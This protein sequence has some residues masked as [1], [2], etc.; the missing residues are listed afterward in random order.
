M[1]LPK[2]SSPPSTA[3]FRQE[4]AEVSSVPD[5]GE[6]HHN[7]KFT[8]ITKNTFWCRRK[9][10]AHKVLGAIMDYMRMETLQQIFEQFRPVLTSY[11]MLGLR[12]PMKRFIH[13]RNRTIQD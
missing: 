5:L 13:P 6:G 9:A 1:D 10:A 8:T 2:I 12:T 7:K 11:K 3:V 4:N